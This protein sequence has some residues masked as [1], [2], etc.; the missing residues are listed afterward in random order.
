MPRTVTQSPEKPNNDYFLSVLE[1]W[2]GCKPPY[3]NSHMRIC[4]TAAKTI[5][6]HQRQFRR[7]KYEKESYLRIDF[8]KAGKVTFYAEFPKKMGLKGRKLGEWPELAIQ[9]AR[10]KA[11]EMGGRSES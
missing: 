9:L 2:E 5:P 1:Y 8:S 4:V 7:S 3:T 10:E 6:K 11:V